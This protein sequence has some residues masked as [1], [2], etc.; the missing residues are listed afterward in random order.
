MIDRLI[1]WAVR[2]RGGVLFLVLALVVAGVWAFS[3]LR[4]DAFPEL[5]NV[6][7]DVL[8]EAPGMSPL[9]VERLVSYPLEVGLQ[10]IPGVTAI[11]SLSRF[12]LSDIRVVFED[13]TDV[14]FARTRVAEQIQAVRSQLPAQTDPQLGPLSGSI[15]EIYQYTLTGGGKT[16]MELRTLE[17]R[18]VRPE[19]RS[20][21]GV[22]DVNSFG[23]FVREVTVTVRPDRLA[24]YGLTLGDVVAALQGN[25]LVAASGY[26]E[27]G[28]EQY[29][30]RGLGQATSAEDVRNTVIRSGAAGVPVIIGDVADVAYGAEARQGAVTMNGQGEV[31]TGVVMALRG[32]N[33]RT[34][35]AHLQEK[36]A[37]IN[38]ALPPGVTIRPYYDQTKLVAGT[39]RT[40]AH[41]LIEGG[42]LV[43]A[44]L[45]LFLGNVR[46]ALVVA[47][48]IPLS[49]LCAFLGIRWLGMS[50]NLMS[51]GAIDFGMI[52]D[53]AVVMAERFVKDLH[54]A[55]EARRFPSGAA[56]LSARITELA[57]EVGRPILCGVLIIMLVYVPVVTLQGLEGRMFR[58]MAITVAIALFGSLLLALAFVPAAST[59]AFRRGARESRLAVRLA[60]WLDRRYTPLLRGTMRRP[61][62][63]VTVAAAIFAASL[64]LVP[65]LGT[66]FVPE[67]AEGSI[68]LTALRDPSVSLPQSLAMQQTLEREIERTPEVTTVL[69]QVGRAEIASD[70]AG[71]D[72]AEMFI[73]LKPRSAWRP[74]FTQAEIA[75]EIEVRVERTVP[76]LSY[77]FS[78]PVQNRLDELT[79][80]VRADLAIKIFGDSLDQNRQLAEQIAE[81]VQRVPGADE[82]QLPASTG[83]TYLNVQMDRR[84][85]ARYGITVRSAQE[86]LAAVVSDEPV[87]QVIEGSYTINVAVRYPA[88]LRSS[89]EAVGGVTVA[90][91]GGMLVPLREF[92]TVRLQA[93]PIMVQ[94]ENGRRLEIVQA[95]VQG[96]DLGGFAAEVRRKVAASI[97][98]P[99]GVFVTYGGSFENQ[100][101]A[102]ARLRVVLPISIIVIGLLLYSSLSS[103]L[104]ALIVLLNLPFA[105]VGGV[106]AIWLRGMHLSVSAGIGFIALFGV[107][108]LNGLV[109][110]STIQRSHGQG[111]EAHEAAENGARQR[112][113]PV[114]MTA[115]VASIGFIPA[116]LSHGTGAEVQ[117]P[118]ATVVIGGL[119]TS[120]LLTVFVLPTLYAWVEGWR[121]RRAA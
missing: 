12:G 40:V 115:A 56:A 114:L 74:G 38:R 15:G 43:I 75:R 46:A 65:R 39:I 67:F 121:E 107:S 93:G 51:L 71:V 76:G 30:L 11:R 86:A 17:D 2:H 4:V 21:A 105:A 84:A 36:V 10:G 31:V 92:A 52:V 24:A 78:Q 104:L 119:I 98:L 42:F 97:R 27:H 79:S 20:V 57:R 28:A 6:Q 29:I 77:S 94:R 63:T 53:G 100:Q 3:T 64:L 1:G 60:D 108:V 68:Q 99:P 34:L 85:M 16:L 120:T 103:A 66:E 19:L 41:N 58:P 72:R 112:L 32:E 106:A 9:E 116:A 96:R 82:V 95:N 91:S 59:L 113:R 23:G 70:P 81:V 7:V 69:S 90:G 25:T 80:G 26:V 109:L 110:L 73:M 48:T 47:A 102:M 18:I 88:E 89:A 55:D 101:R 8:T 62:R 5:S 13:A 83:Q 54:Q 111:V 45:L 44:I 118:L 87:S 22:A 37:Q 117:R 33:S 61:R 50:A 14:Y 49:L 35:V